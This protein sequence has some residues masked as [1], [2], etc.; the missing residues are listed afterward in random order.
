MGFFLFVENSCTGQVERIENIFPTEQ[1]AV[2][3]AQKNR[4]TIVSICTV[5]QYREA[6]SAQQEGI[7]PRQEEVRYV[8]QLQSPQEVDY[9]E[10]VEPPRKRRP[11]MPVFRFTQYHPVGRKIFK[12]ETTNGK[13]VKKTVKK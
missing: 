7:Q 2:D 10:N 1:A 8:P 5:N 9:Q 6:M 4:E 13:G 12:P 11:E 3:Y